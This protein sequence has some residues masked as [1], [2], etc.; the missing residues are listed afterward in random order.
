MLVRGEMSRVTVGVY[1][2]TV[3]RA[4]DDII[5]PAVR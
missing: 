4:T 1:R 2:D 3:E 5:I